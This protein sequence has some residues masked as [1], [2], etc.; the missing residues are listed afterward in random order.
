MTSKTKKIPLN[1]LFVLVG[2]GLELLF[3]VATMVLIVRYVGV[4]A[5]GDYAFARAVGIVLTALI[6]WA[7]MMVIVREAA[8]KKKHAPIILSSS[9]SIHL[10]M[11]VITTAITVLLSI[12][13]FKAGRVLSLYLLLTLCSQTLFVIQRSASC[14]FIAF[15]KAIYD[16]LLIAFTR[17]SNLALV[18]IV[19]VFD[20]QLIGVFVASV[21]APFISLCLSLKLISK[22]LFRIQYSLHFK[23]VKHLFTESASLCFSDLIVNGFT[24]INL[25]LLKYYQPLSQIS[26]FNTQQRLLDPLQVFPK[27]MMVAAMPA[28]SSLAQH[29]NDAGK[30]LN[31]YRLLLKY[32]YLTSILLSFVF[33]VLAPQIVGLFFGADFLGAVLPMQITCISL[34]FIFINTIN[35]HT[36]TALGRQNVIFVSNCACFLM[37]VGSG[38][39]LVL[40]SGAVGASI[41]LVCGNMVLFLMNAFFLNTY[42]KKWAMLVPMVRPTLSCIT[43]FVCYSFFMSKGLII[44]LFLSIVVYFVMLL[45]LGTF[46]LQEIVFIKEHAAKKRPPKRG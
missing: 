45:L 42:I 27:S 35:V 30:L 29:P 10:A 22:R 36:L 18:G 23:T 40:K 28:I 6:A 21:I 20:L 16:S 37:V 41:S 5:F 8:T 15:E 33:C 19:I 25:F 24:H 13:I 26:F 44:S 2:R 39:F 9:I 4:D 3:G 17:V 1:A 31:L 7:N 32:I 34:P 12:Y 11:G 14:M 43:M 46:K 38:Y